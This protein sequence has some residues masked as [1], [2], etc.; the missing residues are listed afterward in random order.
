MKRILAAALL[1]TFAVS[2]AASQY[3]TAAQ[4][5]PVEAGSDQFFAHFFAFTEPTEEAI[6]NHLTGVRICRIPDDGSDPSG[7]T[8]VFTTVDSDVIAARW[9]SRSEIAIETRSLDAAG[10][11]L[12]LFVAIRDNEWRDVIASAAQ[13]RPK[14]TGSILPDAADFVGEWTQFNW[15]TCRIIPPPRPAQ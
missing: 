3:R 14:G 4:C 6:A 2:P 7:C 12:H 1:A 5:A 11:E 10:L 15:A 9:I 13:F 8:P